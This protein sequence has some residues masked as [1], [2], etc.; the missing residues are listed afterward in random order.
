MNLPRYPILPGIPLTGCS[1]LLQAG[2][3][4]RA[5][6]RTVARP[7]PRLAAEDHPLCLTCAV[8][9]AATWL[10]VLKPVLLSTFWTWVSAVRDEITRRLAISLLVRPSETSSTTS[11]SRL[12]RPKSRWVRDILAAPDAPPVP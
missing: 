3:D 1:P 8:R 11:S 12:V 5:A 9:Q 6:G 10:R 4:P 7:T 2:R